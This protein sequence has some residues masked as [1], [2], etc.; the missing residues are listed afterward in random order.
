MK[1]LA[2]LVLVVGL[3]LASGPALAQGGSPSQLQQ[4]YWQE[5]A[6]YYDMVNQ[7]NDLVESYQSVT[8]GEGPNFPGARRLIS[9]INAQYRKVEGLKTALE[10]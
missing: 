4:L 8:S 6:K 5:L 2:M 1:W 10:Q 9:Q 7:Y 3:A